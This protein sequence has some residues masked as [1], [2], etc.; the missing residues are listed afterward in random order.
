MVHY[1]GHRIA[2]DGQNA[3]F[4]ARDEVEVATRIAREVERHPARYA[5]GSLAAGGDILWAEALLASGCEL[6]V[7]LPFALEEFVRCSVAPSG[8]GWVERFHR[9]LDAAREVRYATD[10][11]FLDDDVLYRYGAEYAMGLTLLRARYLDAE[12]RQLAL[13]DG[14]AG[15]GRGRG[16]DRRRHLAARRPAGIDRRPGRPDRPRPDD[17]SAGLPPQGRA[18]RVVRA[19]LFAD[20][21]ASRS[22]PTRSFPASPST[23]SA[24]SPRTARG[25]R[26]RASS[27]RTPGATRSTSCLEDAE[28]AAAC[29]LD[30][31]AA[32][33]RLDLAAEGLPEHL[34]LRLGAHVGPVFPTWD[35][36]L[37]ALAFMGSHVS[38]TARIEPV[39]PPGA[40]Y[41]TAPFAAAL[42]LT[43]SRAVRLRLR[44]PHAG[45]QGLRQAADV[46]AVAA[47]GS[48]ESAGAAPS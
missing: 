36:V 37:D 46:S 2:A 9:C 11:A 13:W 14:G 44:R 23:S 6:H 33:A 42:A 24:P 28:S 48:P 7:V 5:Y 4:P 47:R 31:Q 20:V 8:E 43:G 18:R 16:G 39:T 25:P 35:P 17:P 12:V 19:M 22:S 32:V 38:R 29:A 45:R 40:V 27:T 34:S 3:R 15:P 41:V 10:D 21:R 30:L 26:R 1:C